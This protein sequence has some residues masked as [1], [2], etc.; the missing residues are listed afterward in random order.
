VRNLISPHRLA[1]LVAGIL[2]LEPTARA[3][4][5]QR[6]TTQRAATPKKRTATATTRIKVSK[7]ET[8]SAGGEVA[9]MVRP[10]TA[11]A[12]VPTVADTTLQIDTTAKADTMVKADTTRV[13]DTTAIAQPVTTPVTTPSA[14]T[15]ASP[16][17]RT[18]NTRFGRLYLGFAG[19][20][21]VP[22]GDI[23]NGYDPGFNI[24]LP[25]GWD[26]YR[27]PL[28]VRF[29]LSYDRLMARSTFRNNGQTTALV[30]TGTS[31]YATGSAT[32]P[33]A[34]TGAT[35]G[36]TATGGYSGTARIANTDASLASAMLDAKL[37][38]PVFGSHSPTYLYALAG[39]GVHYFFNYANSLALTNPAAERAK[40][41][42]LHQSNTASTPGYTNVTYSTSGY[43]AVTRLGTNLGAGM[44]WGLGPANLFVEGRYVTVLT[45]DRHTSYWP[46]LLGVTWK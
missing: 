5:Q 44:Q 33:T 28:G 46:M 34:A 11:T 21:S 14:D 36:T 30:T 23:H 27:L 4:A 31:G 3:S 45:K 12:T 25:V 9:P 15:S 37:R 2:A 18:I 40:F 29:D 42:A 43:S 8:R 24:T 20:P 35:G 7:N 13:A 16:R 22:T 41:A 38:L 6:D 19:G 17:P 1:L 10:D 39:G 32:T 26:S